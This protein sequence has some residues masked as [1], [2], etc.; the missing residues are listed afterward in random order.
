MPYARNA[1]DGSRVYFE[2]DGGQGDAAVIHGGIL[3]SVD[4]ERDSPLAQALKGQP[5]E[6][7]LVY[8][9]HRGVGRSHKPTAVEAYAMPLRVAD[10]VAVLDEL[11]VERAHFI[12]ASYGG[13]L[14]FGIGEHAPERVLSLVMGGQQ[15]YAIDPHGPLARL[16]PGAVAASRRDGS[17]EP[18]VQ[19]LE[20]YAGTRFPDVLRAR[21]LDNDPAAIEAASSAMLAEGAISEDLR[22]WRVRCLI[23]ASVGDVDF[24]D[25]AR[26]A[27]DEIPNA[28]FISLQGL[29][30]IGAHLRP[31][32]VL[33]AVLRTLR[34]GGR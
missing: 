8:V 3:D 18:F 5:D 21:Y 25:Q 24:H 9:D 17:L 30:H 6:F 26:R 12:G 19:A 2:D 13:R 31:D 4:A 1:L 22:A 23:Y 15:P 32:P 14:G 28:E 16:L 7:R 34:G 27:A 33:P 11:G 20:T 29:D 10:A